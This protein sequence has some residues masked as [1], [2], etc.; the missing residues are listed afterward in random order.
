MALLQA[1]AEVFQ[2]RSIVIGPV[3]SCRIRLRAVMR[4]YDLRHTAPTLMLQAGVDPHRVQRVL[5]HA[6]LT[7]STGTYAHLAIEDLRWAVSR[8]APE[9]SGGLAVCGHI[10]DVARKRVRSQ[11]GRLP[12]TARG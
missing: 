2:H 4:F 11:R 1:R 8:I 12:K 6:S 9:P 7:T 3:V 10:A 5:R